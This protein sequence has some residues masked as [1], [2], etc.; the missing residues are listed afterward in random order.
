V[1]LRELRPSLRGLVQGAHA[2]VPAPAAVFTSYTAFLRCRHYLEIPQKGSIVMSI[3]LQATKSR[4]T[5]AAMIPVAAPRAHR[6]YC[7]AGQPAACPGYFAGDILPCVCGADGTVLQALS[8]IA[9]PVI[10]R[11]E[12]ASSKSHA[13]PLI[14]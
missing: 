14:A 9:I 10:P 4:T 13:M 11:G 12:E 7:F 2:A 8:R 5:M 1:P 3:R 6:E